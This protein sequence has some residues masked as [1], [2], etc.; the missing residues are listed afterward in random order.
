MTEELKKKIEEMERVLASMTVQASKPTVMNTS[1]I[2]LPRGIVVTEGDLS[3]NVKH[4]KQM[5]NNYLIASGLKY[6]PEDEKIA[7]LLIAIGEDCF[8]LYQNFPLRAEDSTTCE[9]LLE[10]IE[11]NL[12]PQVNKRYERAIFNTTIQDEHE[13]IDQY[14]NRL[15]GLIKNCQYGEI[16]EELLLDRII[17][18]IKDVKLRH[19]LWENREVTLESAINQCRAAEL[20]EKQL[21]QLDNSVM[22]EID[23][24]KIRK[25]IPDEI[26]RQRTPRDRNKCTFC[27]Y[28]HDYT[29]G[30]CPAIG[31]ICRKCNKKNH[32]EKMCRENKSY[33]DVKKMEYDS[34]SDSES[35]EIDEILKIGDN[36]I[37]SELFFITNKCQLSLVKCQL[38]TGASCNVIGI[39]NYRDIMKIDDPKLIK[40]KS[41]LKCF[42]GFI[43]EPLGKVYIQ[44]INEGEVQKLEFEVVSNPHIPL[45][46]GQTCKNLGLI[47]ICKEIL[48]E[49]QNIDNNESKQKKESKKIIEQFEDV[50]TGIGRLEGYVKLELDR[51][52]IPKIQ[53]PRRI[54]IKLREELQTK[55]EEMEKDEIITKVE[56]HSEWVSNIVL[57][58][59]ND[60]LRICI[61]PSDLNKAL[62]DVKYQMPKIEEILPE[63]QDAKVFSTFDAKNGFWQLVL[64]EESSKMTTFW[65][66]FGRYRWLRLP[67]GVK[68]AMEIYQKRQHEVLLGLKGVEVMA[69]DIIVFGR[70]RNTEEAIKNH[71]DNLK[72]ML[73]RLRSVN[74][75]LNKS[76]IKLCETKVKYFGHLLTD[77]GI[78][79]DPSKIK[80]IKEM[81]NPENIDELKRLL[82]MVS[83]LSKFIPNF[84][85]KVE[86]L[87][88]LANS[89]KFEWK[90]VH[91]NEVMLIKNEL[92]SETNLKYFDSSKNVTIQTD[93][94]S[95]ALGCTLMQDGQPVSYA[96]RVLTKTEINY[97][98]IEKETLAIVFACNKFDQYI[99]GNH[100]VIIETDHQP[101]LTIFKK[102]LCSAPRRIQKMLMTLQ[103]YNICLKYKKGK[104]MYVADTLSRLTKN[105]NVYEVYS[106]EEI[107]ELADLNP[108][109]FMKISDK[110]IINLQ[111]ETSKDTE[112]CELL[113]VITKGWPED[114][115]K[116]NPSLLK[117]WKYKEDLTI[118]DGLIL[119][120]SRILVP[121]VSRRELLKKLHSSHQGIEATLKLARDTIFWPNISAEI[122]ELVTSCQ[123]CMKYSKNQPNPEMYSHT[124]PTLPYEVVNMDVMEVEMNNQKLRYLITVDQY[125]DYFDI[126]RLK[127]LS[128]K[129]TIDICRQN[130]ALHGIPSVCIT[131]NGTNFVN[132]DFEKF[133]KE[134]NFTHKMSSPLHQ[135]GNGKAEAAVKIA[136]QLI[137][138]SQ[139]DDG[140]FYKALLIWRNTP[141][142]TESSPN[143]RLF[144]RRTRSDIPAAKF[145]YKPS[146]IQYVPEKLKELR[147]KAKTYYDNTSRKMADLKE[148]DKVYFKKNVNSEIWLPG[149]ILKQY[150]SRSYIIVYNEKQYRRSRVHIKHFND[151]TTSH[152]NT[153]H[154]SFEGRVPPK[155]Q[156]IDENEKSTSE[157]NMC[158]PNEINGDE[159][160]TENESEADNRKDTS[161]NN[162][163]SRSRKIPGRFKDFV[164]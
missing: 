113:D 142:K 114:K 115:T 99:V 62:K 75:K 100:K 128:A 117:Y 69:D 47:H 147:L 48:Q 122:K 148:N 56:E 162:R 138:K 101:L 40:T 111:E 30:K 33:R 80:S 110:T 107:K 38:D 61:D 73:E 64:D 9:K 141:N 23:V 27:G 8:K 34:F 68:P 28:F 108:L 13:N 5:W 98:Q 10:A 49:D 140:D 50:F 12:T 89:D 133:S 124:V 135:Q 6:K 70:G 22:E 43:I 29:R 150:D 25:N 16:E 136:K 2:P 52:I 86:N 81:K 57:V 76:K 83:Y 90:K 163:P 21:K 51:K 24:K 164:L 7:V 132:K 59:R 26:K 151:Y 118:Y 31:Q 103:R 149:K 116:L 54:P 3:M 19:R 44:C 95:F 72:L 134:W 82:G 37:T 97:A 143:Q 92:S 71:N 161:S 36:V 66:P 112:L 32:F 120:Q 93:S 127:D 159:S 77:K 55:L 35:S 146:V 58:K 153:E 18:S 157:T 156:E 105:D 123:N 129:T 121:R 39:E 42:G 152:R 139:E 104:E 145:L 84:S 144:S 94:S 126:N 15:R 14:I 41:K 131:D 158:L 74:M 63:L 20:T 65:T 160:T 67:F 45:L 88:K 46:G 4:F 60:K 79:P 53:T 155:V 87:R 125:S 1:N 106:C 102:P 96:S 11:T 85:N 119:K 154:N 137:K 78:K 17:V 109:E 91:D 130:F